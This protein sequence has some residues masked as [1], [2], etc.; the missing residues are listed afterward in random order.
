MT[1]RI[2]KAKQLKSAIKMLKRHS[3]H[4][5]LTKAYVDK[6]YHSYII[7]G[8]ILNKKTFEI[9]FKGKHIFPLKKRIGNRVEY[10]L[11]LT[12]YYFSLFIVKMLGK[13]FD[14]IKL[15]KPLKPINCK[16]TNAPDEFVFFKFLR[17]NGFEI[18]DEKLLPVDT[19]YLVS[20]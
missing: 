19:I 11:D 9:K 2:K 7:N 14:Y 10:Y 12:D 3:L 18:V 8:L 16:I 20:Y 17:D 1:E 13:R 15:N 5:K 4:P 6:V